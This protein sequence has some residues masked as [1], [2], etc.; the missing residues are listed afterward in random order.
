MTLPAL[1]RRAEERGAKGRSPSPKNTL[2]DALTPSINPI[3]LQGDRKQRWWWGATLHP[4]YGRGDRNWALSGFAVAQP[5]DSVR[6]F[7]HSSKLFGIIFT[8]KETS[9]KCYSTEVLASVR[10]KIKHANTRSTS[11]FRLKRLKQRAFSKTA[12]TPDPDPAGFATREN[13]LSPARSLRWE[14][15]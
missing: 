1:H 6:K 9:L 13:L 12:A 14:K 5:C 3:S 7:S 8:K 2:L 11:K 10:R 15:L 4:N